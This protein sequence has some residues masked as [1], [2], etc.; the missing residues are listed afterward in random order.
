MKEVEY[1]G[2]PMDGVR[3]ESS[4]RSKGSPAAPT[5]RTFRNDVNEEVGKTT[6]LGILMAQ[7]ARSEAAGRSRIPEEDNGHIEHHF[8][9]IIFLLLLILAFGIGVGMYA[10]I[11]GR[12]STPALSEITEE[13][14]TQTKQRD[15]GTIAIGHSSREQILTAILDMFHAATL[16]RGETKLITLTTTDR[17][18]EAVAATTSALFSA[19]NMTVQSETGN[20]VRSLESTVAYGLALDDASGGITGFLELRSRSYAE[21]FAGM[22]R[23]E[24]TMASDLIPMLKPTMK[25]S[26]VLLLRGRA[27]NDERIEGVSARVLS[28][29]DGVSSLAYAF[30]PD[31]KTLIITGGRD[32]LRALIAQ[33]QDTSK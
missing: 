3:Y 32:V 14:K 18:G 6:R 28:D 21:T 11:G 1:D 17:A 29:P 16:A 9:R 4:E 30:L 33:A 23:L 20:L 26:D 25:K 10:L 19:L 27:W 12:T 24:K 7:R 15:G 22:L 13:G 8:G 5:I 2:P 31:R